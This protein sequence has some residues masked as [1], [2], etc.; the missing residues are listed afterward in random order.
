MLPGNI[1][2]R[3]YFGKLIIFSTVEKQLEN[4]I[5]EFLCGTVG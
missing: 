3:Y 1:L 5:L 4:S 2:G